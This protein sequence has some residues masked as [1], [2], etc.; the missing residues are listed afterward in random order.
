MLTGLTPP[1]T[2]PEEYQPNQQPATVCMERG[3]G[4]AR[5][6]V[7]RLRGRLTSGD[8]QSLHVLMIQSSSPDRDCDL[9]DTS[10]T[11]NNWKEARQTSC[12]QQTAPPQPYCSKVFTTH[13]H[14]P[15]DRPDSPCPV[16]ACSGQPLSGLIGFSPAFLCLPRELAKSFTGDEQPGLVSPDSSCQV[17]SPHY[18]LWCIVW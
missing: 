11:H 5:Q 2:R 18:T 1:I 14:R 4:E 13:L 7:R 17:V 15:G 16:P 8:H 10:H 12:R 9:P 3:A 6:R